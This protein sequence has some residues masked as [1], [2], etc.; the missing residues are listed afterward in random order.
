MEKKGYFEAALSDFMFDVAAGGAI[1]H[2]VDRGHS[3]EQI[4]KELDYP[5]PF[6]KVE[7]AVYRYLLESGIL[8][9]K[10]PEEAKELP[11]CFPESRV[12][13][14][15][16][17]SL[18]GFLEEYGEENCYL[19]C[20]FGLWRA[21]NVQEERNALSCLTSREQEYIWGIRW[22]QR[23]MYHR[24][25][26]RMREISMK[27]LKHTEKEWRFFLCGMEEAGEFPV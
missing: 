12:R 25:T 6:A 26:S 23:I 20:P 10:L 22:E 18:M 27:L 13:K 16:C 7:K 4:V 3:V 2:L 5:V 9:S 19:E 15:A 1:R 21:K 11:V 14:D 17:R 24:L 8:L